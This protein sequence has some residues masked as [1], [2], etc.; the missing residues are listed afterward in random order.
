MYNEC[1]LKLTDTKGGKRG[2][3][4]RKRIEK[5]GYVAQVTH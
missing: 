1:S 4:W 2:R 3:W 5:A